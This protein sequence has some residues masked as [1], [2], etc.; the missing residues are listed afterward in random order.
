M[1]EQAR[2]FTTPKIFD[3]QPL[4][5]KGESHFQFEAYANILARIIASKDTKNP[6]T[7][8]IDGKWGSGKTSL[9]NILKGKLDETWKGREG[10][11]LSFLSA[12]ESQHFSESFRR[13]K[14]VWFNAWKYAREEALFVALIE[15][16]GR[17]M[18]KDGFLTKARVKRAVPKQEFK[19]LKF[20]VS[21]ISQIVSLGRVE[22]DPSK[23]EQETNF[24]K[25]MPFLD[26]FQAA[27]K[28]LLDLYIEKHG[29]LVIFIDDLDRC[30][31]SKAVQVLEAIKL[32]MDREGCIFVL[33]IDYGTVAAAVQAHYEAEHLEKI[34][35]EDYLD[36][37]IQV[38]FPL[39]PLRTEDVHKYIESLQLEPLERNLLRL[40]SS[41]I[42]TNPRKIKTFLN[43]F[44]LQLALMKSAGI[45]VNRERLIEWLVLNEI[46]PEFCEVIGDI[47]EDAEKVEFIKA[48]K[49]FA[50][51]SESQREEML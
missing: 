21:A 35:G 23:F 3:D 39:P 30:L 25:N 43:H 11:K 47:E 33:G 34:T 48:I 5:E 14:T 6:L 22:L 42:P 41:A 26:E 16:I 46:C 49:K 12:E 24:R 27:F 28:R 2:Q 37:M 44:E 9:M 19:R 1:A 50:D 10:N 15:Q 40:I 31:P 17:E 32:F 36:K 38:R 20:A 8:G 4:G 13:C 45:S 29:V 18:E 7:I 51:A